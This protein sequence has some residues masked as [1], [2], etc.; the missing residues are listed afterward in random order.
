MAPT[1]RSGT[2]RKFNL[3]R[4]V[5][6][7]APRL[8]KRRIMESKKRDAQMM[9]EFGRN[10]KMM[11]GIDEYGT[12]QRRPTV[13]TGARKLPVVNAR[14]R[15]ARVMQR[16]ARE[17]AKR[18]ANARRAVENEVARL[19]RA[20]RAQKVD[21]AARVIQARRRGA[22][23]RRIARAA[24]RSL[25]NETTIVRDGQG[26]VRIERGANLRHGTKKRWAHMLK[27]K[28]KGTRREVVQAL[29]NTYGPKD[30]HRHQARGR[31]RSSTKCVHVAPKR[32]LRRIAKSKGI[33]TNKNE[34]KAQICD[35]LASTPLGRLN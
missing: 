13:T 15:A 28:M 10:A 34:T 2:K 31:Y 32:A 7:V 35:K 11:R 27:S 1:T 23:G 4:V 9:R 20:G 5:N 16:Y 26:V 33:A 22:L 30:W 17:G 29:R 18:R 12:M 19:Y 14:N 6:N 25:P 3:A 8:A 21:K 24:R